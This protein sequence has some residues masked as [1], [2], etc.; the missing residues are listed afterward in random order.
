[1]PG[2]LGTRTENVH[3]FIAADVVAVVVVIAVVAAVVVAALS[4][5]VGVVAAVSFE[6]G[7]VVAAVSLEVVAA[8]VGA[9]E[10]VI[11][12]KLRLGSRGSSLSAVLLIDRIQGEGGSKKFTT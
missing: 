11:M 3:L 2:Q 10:F 9:A 8:V 1:V 4:F 6:V 12:L 5:E 7:D